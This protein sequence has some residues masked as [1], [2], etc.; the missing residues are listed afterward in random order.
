MKELF[1]LLTK[2][3]VF[4]EA[5]NYFKDKIPLKPSEFYKLAEE[6]KALAFTVSGYTSAQVIYKFH[7]EILKAIENGTTM[8]DFKNNMNEFLESKGYEGITNFQAD[9]IFRTNMQTAY[10]V[11]HYKQMTSSEVMKLR[12]YWQYD[13]V[14]DKHTRPSHLAMD[15]RVFRADDPIW[16]IWYPPNGF[17]CRCGIITLSERQVKERGL[18]VEQGAPRAAEVGGK[19]VN[20]MPDPKF[21]KNPAK[22]SFEP[23]LKNYPKSI[24]KAFEKREMSTK[25][26]K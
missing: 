15:G 1:D 11:G 17:R 23:E 12:P 21:S 18:R 14:N 7:D 24:E 4:E 3:I 20:V 22:N 9:N 26:K 16:D 13:A 19:F 5:V 2:D 6:Y 10:Q 25:G 8:R